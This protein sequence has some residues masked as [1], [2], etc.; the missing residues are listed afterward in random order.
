M[1]EK[2]ILI[3]G[4]KIQNEKYFPPEMF[5]YAKHIIKM[6]KNVCRVNLNF[7]FKEPEDKDI[8]YVNN[9]MYNHYKELSRGVLTKKQLHKFEMTH[10]GTGNNRKFYKNIYTKFYEILHKKEYA[11]V[12][13]QTEWGGGANTINNKILDKLKC[14]YKFS[15]QPRCG[16]QALLYFISQGYSVSVMGFS[17]KH[18]INYT[19]E[20]DTAVNSRTDHKIYEEWKIIKWLHDNNYIDSTLCMV[21]NYKLPLLDCNFSKPTINYLMY[22]LKT[23]GIIILNNYFNHEIIEEIINEYDRVLIDHKDKIDVHK[24]TENVYGDE[25]LFYCEKYS[26]YIKDNFSNDILFNNIA[27]LYNTRINKKTLINR[28][29]YKKNHPIA[30]GGGWHRDNHHCQFKAVMYLSDVSSKNGCFKWITHSNERCIGKPIPR[31]DDQNRDTR[32]D[33]DTINNIINDKNNNCHLIDIIGK[34][35]TIILADTT[36]IHGGKII[37][38]GERKAITQYFFT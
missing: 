27:K 10:P 31:E 29:K 22:L 25:R 20:G 30:S 23:N 28:V 13:C 38:E 32:Y 5:T 15:K 7:A 11:S 17:F 24:F 9:N 14:P 33:N 1:S 36:Y 8:F 4:D 6:H 12:I 3:L 26:Q 18:E 2:K 35:G 34:K 37:E 21:E 19:K 16:C